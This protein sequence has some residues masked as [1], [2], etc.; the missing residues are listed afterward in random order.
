MKNIL[1][2]IDFSP[3]GKEVITVASDLARGMGA[4]L[5][6]VHVAA[7]DPEFIGYQTGPAHVREQRVDV[8]RH[9]HA[10]LQTMAAR[11]SDQGL[12]SEALLVQGPTTET[13]LNEVDRLKADMIVMGSHGRSGLFK[14]LVGSV[15]EQIIAESR[16]PVLV[17]P[18]LDR[19]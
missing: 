16:V 15:C 4:K 8:L 12:S 19:R 2:P 10:D 13:L 11:L 18:S 17:V 9:E 1:V 14:A 3:L 6:L 5:W 7:P